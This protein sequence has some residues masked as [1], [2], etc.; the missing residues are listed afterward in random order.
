MGV[1]ERMTGAQ[2]VAKRRAALRAKGLKLRQYWV[3][4][5]RNADVRAQLAGEARTIRQ[6]D[7]TSGVGAYLE[8]IRGDVWAGEPDYDWGPSGPPAG[9]QPKDARAG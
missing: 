5:L 4:D 9:P 6:M 3:P 7:A 8:S 1:C 2:R